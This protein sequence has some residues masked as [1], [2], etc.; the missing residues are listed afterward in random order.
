[1]KTIVITG[2]DGSGKTTQS[3]LLKSKLNEAK[4]FSVWD[5]IVNPNYKDW[6]VYKS[7]PPVEKYVVNLNPTS[8]ALFVFHAFDFAYQQAIKSSAKFVIF[9][10]YWYKYLAVELAMGADKN[11]IDFIKKRY[12]NPDICF[13]LDMKIDLLPTRKP[14]ISQYESGTKNGLDY[15]NFIKIQTLSKRYLEDFLPD[16]TIKIS[17]SKS[18][19]QISKKIINHIQNY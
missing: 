10:S 12:L 7:P 14:T 19:D 13:Y 3:K 8:R 1:M 15:D 18:I 11:L 2:I 5:I 9:D 17:A 6:S 4:V 16:N